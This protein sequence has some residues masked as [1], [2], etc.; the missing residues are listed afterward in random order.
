[1]CSLPAVFPGILDVFF[2]H[3]TTA[4]GAGAGVSWLHCRDSGWSWVLSDL[5][6]SA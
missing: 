5:K 4:V 2:F 6:K 3:H 1:M